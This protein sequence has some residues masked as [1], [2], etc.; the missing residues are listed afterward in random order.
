MNL[1]FDTDIL[2][3]FGKIRRLDLSMILKSLLV[4]VVLTDDELKA[5][6]NEIERKDRV[7]IKDKGVY[8]DRKWQ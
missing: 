8:F 1:V 7:V 3:T 2:S 4:A 6:I 5:V